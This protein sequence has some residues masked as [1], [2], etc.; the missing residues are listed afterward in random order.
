MKLADLILASRAYLAHF[1]YSEYPVCFEALMKG[2]DA[3]LLG[4]PLRK[5]K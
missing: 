5:S 3:N 4:L 1:S 2:F